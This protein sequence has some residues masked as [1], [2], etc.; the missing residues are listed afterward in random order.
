MLKGNT[1]GEV[2]RMPVDYCNK[3]IS[4]HPVES[5]PYLDSFLLTLGK[6]I[7]KRKNRKRFEEHEVENFLQ[8][9]EENKREDQA[10]EKM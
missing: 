8:A 9:V 6:N 3:N 2:Y 4:F 5:W 1:I 10:F 7:T